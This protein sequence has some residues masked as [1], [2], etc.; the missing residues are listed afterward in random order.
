MKM[1][2]PF[3]RRTAAAHL[4]LARPFRPSLRSFLLLT[5]MLASTGAMAERTVTELQPSEMSA[6]VRQHPKVVVQFTSSD[7]RCGFCRGADELFTQGVAQSG[8]DGWKY[9]RVQWPRWNDMPT[10]SPPVKVAGV[11]DHQIY[12]NGEY[13]GSGGGR[14]KDAA[15]LM[16]SIEN[17][18]TRP[19]PVASAASAQK[20]AQMTPEIQ[21]GLRFYAMRKVLGSTL[22]AC[23]RQHHDSKPVYATQ[24]HAWGGSNAADLKLGTRAMFSVM[25]SEQHPFRDEEARQTGLV[26]AKMLDLVGIAEGKPAALEQCDKLAASLGKF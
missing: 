16:A 3:Q 9:A 24:L 7:Q 11:P 17:L 4:R 14:A 18:G 21:T 19:K 13:K 8:K 25:G 6:F 12:E 15:S 2:R 10:F 20:P 5:S 22:H 26:R 23:E 1:N